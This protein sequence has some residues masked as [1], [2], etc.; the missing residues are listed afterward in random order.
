MQAPRVA[1]AVEG[2]DAVG[3]LLPEVL[4]LSDP[5]RREVSEPLYTNANHNERTHA[6]R[7]RMSDAT[8]E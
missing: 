5:L 8:R 3:V 7:M 4:L 1:I 2:N 6:E